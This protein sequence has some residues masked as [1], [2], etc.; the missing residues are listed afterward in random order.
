MS[1]VRWDRSDFS[2]A[3]RAA[4][5]LATI[6]RRERYVFATRL[7]WAIGESRPA[8]A[9]ARVE[10]TGRAYQVRTEVVRDAAGEGRLVR[11]EEEITADCGPVARFTGEGRDAE[12]RTS[13]K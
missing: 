6:S 11:V 2:S 8:Q 9:H 10:D 4:R 13:W 12:R 5:T 7:G 1:R 3:L